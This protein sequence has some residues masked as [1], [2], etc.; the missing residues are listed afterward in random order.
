MTVMS[1]HKEILMKKTLLFILSF[2]SLIS[3]SQEW[4][5]V[6]AKWFYTA[7]ING[8]CITIESV[9]DSIIDGN[10][11]KLIDIRY[12][13]DNRLIST[14]IIQ[15]KGDSLLY[16]NDGIFHLFYNFSAKVNDTVKVHTKK[17]TPTM[18]FLNYGY[19]T[20]LDR[21]AYKIASYDSINISGQW[22]R[23]QQVDNLY[24]YSLW[25]ISIYDP[26]I[27]ERIGSLCYFFGRTAGITPED[28]VGQLRCYTDDSISYKAPNWEYDCD[29]D[30]RT[31]LLDPISMNEINIY[32]NPF[33]TE[34]IIEVS[35]QEY[36]I[37]TVYNISGN[38]VYS[39]N[40]SGKGSIGS[41]LQKGMYILRID[42]GN[43]Q[44][45]FKILKR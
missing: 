20:T 2:I 1:K 34:I 10:E 33:E 9:K 17:F 37:A 31:G 3:T 38:I 40:C 16:L 23:T 25:S 13:S 42:S 18:G 45:H 7:P 27:I 12:C 19:P 14:E 21:F 24:N 36:F 4:A 39:T 29:Y 43:Q 30:I 6:G 28:F 41:E 26:A 44:R 15:Q 11:S 22:L 8:K 32:P 35:D 5:P